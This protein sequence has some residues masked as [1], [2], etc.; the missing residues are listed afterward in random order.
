MR[1]AIPKRRAPDLRANDICSDYQV[2]SRRRSAVRKVHVNFVACFFQAL[3][4]VAEDVGDVVLCDIKENPASSPLENL[5]VGGE[6][7]AIAGL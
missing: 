4:P 5:N 6:A 2:E 7:L 3:N 1:V